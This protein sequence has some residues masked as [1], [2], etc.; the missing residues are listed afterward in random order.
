MPVFHLLLLLL[1]HLSPTG[2]V[3]LRRQ[4]SFVPQQQLFI[5]ATPR[6]LVVEAKK[7]RRKE[8]KGDLPDEDFNT[9]E[10]AD[11]LSQ[12][13]MESLFEVP[14]VQE[15]EA[16]RVARA[17]AVPK[18]KEMEN[19][20]ARQ[21]G[22]D[23]KRIRRQDLDEL[24]S[25][26]ELDPSADMQDSTFKSEFDLTSMLLGEAGRSFLGFVRPAYLQVAHGIVLST[27]VLCAFVEYPGNPLTELPGEIREFLKVRSVN[28]SIALLIIAQ[29]RTFF[30]PCAITMRCSV[31]FASPS[32]ALSRALDRVAWSLFLVSMRSLRGSVFRRPKKSAC[33]CIFG[34]QRYGFSGAWP[35]T[36]YRAPRH[37]ENKECG[38]P[39]DMPELTGVFKISKP[40]TTGGQT[41]HRAG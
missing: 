37:N 7:R 40:S 35:F 2:G 33:P 19:E 5:S 32:H 12:L 17:Q 26:L 15:L 25:L 39:C 20:D 31:A 13:P 29:P 3:P 27:S 36:R 16:K 41:K 6:H 24:R 14:D 22:E 18:A 28:C 10:P 21:S 8:P 34:C 9:N 38:V 23:N 1:L 30:L 11:G 4:A